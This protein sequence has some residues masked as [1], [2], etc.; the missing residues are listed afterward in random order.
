MQIRQHIPG[1]VSGFEPKVAAFSSL[2]ELTDL[3]FVKTFAQEPNF[4]R[5]SIG[6]RKS[7]DEFVM[8]AEF[9]GG[10]NW[11]V[12]GFLDGDVDLPRW[13]EDAAIQKKQALT[14]PSLQKKG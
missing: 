10:A 7:G 12:V 4:E 2:Q 1:F 3:D 13:D 8:L 11:W 6:K 14:I 9:N 5:F